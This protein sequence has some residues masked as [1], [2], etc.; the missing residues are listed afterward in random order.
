MVVKTR[1]VRVLKNDEDKRAKKKADDYGYSKEYG[2]KIAGAVEIRK[3]SKAPVAKDT[4]KTRR[5]MV[6]PAKKSS[7]KS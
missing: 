4:N 2:K 3:K 5:K 7:Y 1:K 6:N